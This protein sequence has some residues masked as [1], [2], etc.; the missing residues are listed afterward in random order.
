MRIL[1]ILGVLLLILILIPVIAV[2][3][4]GGPIAKGVVRSLN[5]N[6]QTEIRVA[7]YDVAFWSTFPS[8]SV[9]LRE[10]Q[11][12]GSDGSRLLDAERLAFLL[13]LGSLFGKVRVE[14]VVVEDGTLQLLADVDGNTNYQLMGYTPVGEEEP[15]DEV[16]DAT[17]F[18]IAEARLIGME[19]LYRDAQLSVDLAAD[20]ERLIFSGDFGADTYLLSTEGKLFIRHLD[21]SG[22]RYVNEQQLLLNAATEVDNVGGV[23]TLAPLE[24]RTGDLELGVVGTLRPTEDG[25][26]TDLRVDS[27][28]GN[29]EDVIGLIPPA[30]A[31]SLAELETRGRL[32]LG[33]SVQGAW[34]ERAY[35]RIEGQMTFTDGRVGS[36][37]TNIGARDLNLRALFTY[38]DGP[39][40]G[41]QNIRVEELSGNFKGE[42]FSLRLEVED[43]NA[44]RIFFQADGAFHLG[45]LPGLLPEG[46]VEDGDGYVR[47]EGLRV[48]GEYADMIQPRRMG[49]VSARGTIRFD[50]AE[51]EINEE[52][53]VFPTGILT[54]NDNEMTLADL[55]FEG[56]GTELRMDGR[57]RNLIP[58]L[59]ADSLNSQDAELEFA[60]NLTGESLDIDALIE[61]GGPTEE[62]EQAAAAAGQTDSL[63][64]KTVARRTLITDLLRGT[65]EADLEEWNYGEIEGEDFRGQLIFEPGQLDVRG[66]TAAMDGQLRLDGEVYFAELLRMDGR[67]KAI[68]IDVEQFFAQSE[69]FDQ[70]VLV[71]DN[72]EGRMNANLFI[73]AYFDEEGNF[74]YPKLKVLAGVSVTEGE[75]KDFEMLENFAFALKAGDLERVRFTKLENY[76]EIVDE[77]I[78]I[79]RMFIQSSAMNL[80]LSGSHTFEQYL[81]YYIKVNAG[82]AIANKIRRHDDDLE[83]LP[84]RRRGF[85]NV[86]YTVKGPLEN[87]EVE[88]DKRGVKNDFKRSD[89]RKTRVRTRL[90]ELFAE[91]I[92]L[93]EDTEET[94][95]VAEG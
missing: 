67:V 27:R 56:P 30:Y 59:F 51:L 14:E 69:N 12:A 32:S 91:P 36:P 31:G 54:L 23:Y 46:T 53:L 73:Q 90:E 48:L 70:E 81:D 4:F 20:V 93:I 83:V 33:A 5:K 76:F 6:L 77:T 75:L 60:A 39:K 17:E 34:T 2:S 1:K 29:L 86:Y 79:P 65:F 82:Q 87:Y 50:D 28:S 43:V 72:L 10:V 26:V 95:D 15:E 44:P 21:Q 47:V 66:V 18:N 42:P 64:A 88:A 63:R 19:L 58:V 57:A 13:D 84:A 68:D 37:R 40:G 55:T 9:N 52:T 8:L 7:E 11:V 62:E 78:Y 61:L 3:F 71:A 92:E 45:A 24:V 89:Y 49:A 35:P 80:E 41:V 38:L 16:G 25:L 85:F 94:E 22:E 74:D